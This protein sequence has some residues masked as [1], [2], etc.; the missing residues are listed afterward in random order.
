MLNWFAR[1]LLV[2]T[3][4]APMLGAVA[5]NQIAHGRPYVDWLPWLAATIILAFLC[6]LVLSYASRN[7]EKHLFH[8]KEIEDKDKEVLAFLLTYL[9]PFLATDKLEFKGEWV[10]GSY[11]MLIIIVTIVH[12]GAH[13]FNPIMGILYH[14]YTVKDSGGISC[15]LIARK[16]L[17]KVDVDIETVRLAYNIYLEW[18][19][20]NA[21]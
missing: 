2:S 8:I 9:L 12:S 21:T 1:L 13:H 6:W 18:R 11:I 7:G 5:I 17:Q 4:L 10:T 19:H 3:T 15:L 16:P 20:R 14:F